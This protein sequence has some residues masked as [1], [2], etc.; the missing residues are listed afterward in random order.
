MIIFLNVNTEKSIF[1][2]QKWRFSLGV[3]K[4]NAFEGYL[5]LKRRNCDY[6]ILLTRYLE[7]RDNGIRVKGCNVKLVLT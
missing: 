5:C 7:F 4:L 6:K 3:T 2:G 1:L